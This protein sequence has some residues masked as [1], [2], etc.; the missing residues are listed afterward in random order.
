MSD[1]IPRP[2]PVPQT[3]VSVYVGPSLESIRSIAATYFNV[4]DAFLDPYGVPTVLV[5]A[6]PVK[7]KFGALIRQIAGQNLVAAIRGHGDT[8]TLKFFQK[9][10]MGPPR[11][12]INVVLF[13]ASLGTVFFAGF[14][15]WNALGDIIAPS[16]NPYSE[17]G[18]FAIGLMAI[19]GLHEFGHQVATRYHGLD[20]TLPYFIPGPPYLVP[21]GTF[22]AVISLREPPHNR[23]QLFD[24][25]L[26]GPLVG[27]AAMI[28]VFIA[29]I[30][31]SYPLSGDQVGNLMNRGV[32]FGNS[33]PTQPLIFSL[34]DNLTPALRPD[35]LSA[36]SNYSQLF[37]A[38]QIGALLTFL[39]LI[40]AWQLDGGHI[41]RATFGAEG[42]RIAT[43]LG[44]FALFIPALFNYTGF[45]GF[46]VL[47]LIFMSF[48]RRGLAGVEPL[49]D[50]SPISSW[51]K[52]M[53]IFGLAAL[54]LS[55]SLIPF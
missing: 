39:N 45:I 32:I 29:A 12:W 21:F 54:F 16:A 48:S 30:V 3:T 25:G 47:L 26:S 44:I 4:K 46:A 28:G 23:D 18:V 7:Q 31:F 37:F 13:L 36:S 27:F 40:P 10:Q 9:P 33:W 6:E 42:H 22:G 55:F 2:E 38:T 41:W 35:L 11:K 51:R 34:L 52:V 1:P 53:F 8:L 50:V 43:I 17:G 5:A 20:A 19:I 14:I 15:L 49:D 24:L